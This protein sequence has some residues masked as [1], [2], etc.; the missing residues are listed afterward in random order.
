MPHSIFYI[1]H[2]DEELGYRDPKFIFGTEM[3]FFS[4]GGA[5]LTFHPGICW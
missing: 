2:L 1:S 4:W 3:D 5:F